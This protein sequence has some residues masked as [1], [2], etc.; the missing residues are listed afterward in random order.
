MPLQRGALRDALLTAN[1]PDKASRRA[2]SH[3]RPS[4]RF[5]GAAALLI[6]AALALSHWH[7]PPTINANVH[8]VKP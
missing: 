4:P 3:G 6:A 5:V 8:L 2:G 7:V 1:V